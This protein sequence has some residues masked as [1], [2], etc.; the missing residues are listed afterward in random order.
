MSFLSEILRFPAAPYAIRSSSGAL[1]ATRVE[2]AFDSST[3]RRGLL[4]RTSFPPGGA[5]ILAPCSAIHTCFMRFAIDLIF[6]AR[7][8]LV[9][10]TYRRLRPWRIACSLRAFAVIE[11]PEG[12]LDQAISPGDRVA[13]V[14][15]AGQSA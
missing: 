3:R 12:A 5:V 6:V 13:L 15:G 7:D 14:P 11:M 9:L 8:G 2:G 1:L 10:K 4:G